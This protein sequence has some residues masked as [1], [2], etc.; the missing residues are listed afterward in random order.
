[1]IFALAFILSMFHRQPDVILVTID[2]VMWQDIYGSNSQLLVPNLYNDFVKQGIAVGKMSPI[3]ASGKNHV[4]L[5][6]YLEITRGHPSLDCQSNDCYHPRI[7]RTIL[8][9]FHSPAVFSSWRTIEKTIPNNLNVYHD[10]GSGHYRYDEQTEKT[11]DQYLQT[12]AP[13]FL[14]VSLGDTDEWA[15]ANNHDQYLKSLQSADLYIH[16][17]VVRFP[18][19]NIIVT[20]D[21]GRNRNFRDHGYDKDSERV[22][23]MI[24]GMQVPH[25][26]FIKTRPLSLSN[27]YPTILDLQM[28]SHS[29]N[30]ILEN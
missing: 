8:K 17:L 10:N 20:T 9:F 2:G 3:I 21:H 5:V 7:D 6:G 4:S 1:M 28:G 27:I 26:G 15:H 25:K 12:H 22:W 14:W 24:R 30:S 23:L 18:D 19:S 13:D 11:A 29:P 16:S